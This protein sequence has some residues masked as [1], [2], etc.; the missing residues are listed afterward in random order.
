MASVSAA[1]VD[2]MVTIKVLYQ[3]LTRRTKMPLRDMVPEALE[4][5]VS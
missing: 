1:G 5:N 4:Q 3:G 2:P